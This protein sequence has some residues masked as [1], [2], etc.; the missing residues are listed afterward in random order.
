[1]RIE[2]CDALSDLLALRSAPLHRLQPRL[3][4]S[5]IGH[6][7]SRFRHSRRG[8][9][10]ML[11]HTKRQFS[12]GNDRLD[13]DRPLRANGFNKSHRL[14]DECVPL[15]FPVAHVSAPQIMSLAGRAR[16]CHLRCLPLWITLAASAVS[17]R[18]PCRFGAARAA[19]WRVAAS[20]SGQRQWEALSRDAERWQ[21]AVLM[22]TACVPPCYSKIVPSH[23]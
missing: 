14:T 12:W 21:P 23:G 13:G 9:L 19:P 5:F 17:S 4:G 18:R 8:L 1:M 22:L 15:R 2:G 6:H 10:R 7:M 16:Y 3:L 11:G 20:H